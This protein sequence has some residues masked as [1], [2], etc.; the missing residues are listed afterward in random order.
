LVRIIYEQR[1]A[2]ERIQQQQLE[3]I[4]KLRNLTPE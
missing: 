2:L 4:Q 1:P 3:D